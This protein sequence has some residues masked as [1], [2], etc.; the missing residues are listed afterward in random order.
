VR[1]PPAVFSVLLG[2]LAAVAIPAAVVY[3][4]RSTSV[5]LIWAGVAVP[6]AFVLG[7]AAIAAA[8][9]GRR[10]AQMTLLHRSGSAT[11]RVG[12]LLGFLGVLLAATGA[13]ALAVY[14]ILT[15]RGGT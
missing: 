6:V 13:V 1:N 15:Y 9:K 7:L 8:R 3:A 12:R 11:A 2:L 14:E 4:D 10:R 5:E